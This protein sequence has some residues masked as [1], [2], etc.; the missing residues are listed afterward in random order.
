LAPG[1]YDPRQGTPVGATSQT[2]PFGQLQEP[3]GGKRQKMP[4]GVRCCAKKNGKTTATSASKRATPKKRSGKNK[5]VFKGE[6]EH[7]SANNKKTGKRRKIKGQRG[8][9][10]ETPK[11]GATDSTT[12]LSREKDGLYS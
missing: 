8:W 11:M 4:V 12:G 7:L 10:Q 2:C 5:N 1:M 9:G 3:W 6:R